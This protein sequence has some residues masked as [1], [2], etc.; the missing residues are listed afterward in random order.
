MARYKTAFNTLDVPVVVDDEGRS[1]PGRGWAPVLTSVDQ[2]RA[3]VDQGFLVYVT[4]DGDSADIDADA[5]EALAAT[6]ALNA[7]DTPEEI[8]D[9]AETTGAT[10]TKAARRS[11]ASEETD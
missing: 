9:A 5:R 3:A 8:A 1:I 10:P 4:A 6:D 11:R 7:A 2:V